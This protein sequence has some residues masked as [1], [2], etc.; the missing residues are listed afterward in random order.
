MKIIEQKNDLFKS[1]PSVHPYVY[2]HCVSSDFALGAGIARIFKSKF[3]LTPE[4]LSLGLIDDSLSVVDVVCN[5]ITK[6]K[7][8]HKPTLASLER[9]LIS[10]K[11]YCVEKEIKAI[12]MP[13]IGCGLDR[14]SW[15][16]VRLI[17][18]SVFKETDIEI[19]VFYL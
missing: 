10:L 11:T 15:P 19:T 9:A 7:Y 8:W 13:R 14:L 6:K 5:L 18:D 17:I 12:I 1:R 2:A 3:N 16:E 4:R